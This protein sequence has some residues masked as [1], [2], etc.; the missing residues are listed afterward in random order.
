MHKTCDLSLGT[1]AGLQLISLQQLATQSRCDAVANA[2]HAVRTCSIA[3]VSSFELQHD[4][5]SDEIGKISKGS[6]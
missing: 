4:G 6:L 1:K 3:S 2:A 5:A